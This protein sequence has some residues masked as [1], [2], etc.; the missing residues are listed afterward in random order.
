MSFRHHLI[1]LT[2]ILCIII[3]SVHADVPHLINFQGTLTDSAGN[4]I[5]GTRTMWFSIYSDSTGG[6]PLW[7]EQHNSIVIAEGLYHVILGS[8][9]P[10]PTSLFDGSTLWF[11][12]RIDPDPQELIPRQPLISV[13]YGYKSV[14]S[15][16]AN[17]LQVP[18]H[19]TGTPEQSGSI[20]WGTSTSNTGVGVL[21][22]NT[23]SGNTGMLGGLG[24]GVRGNNNNGNLGYLGYSGYGV[25]GYH[26]SGNWGLLGS[27]NYGVWGRH[28][29]NGNIGYLG[30]DSIGVYGYSTEYAGYFDG[31]L[32][33][34]GNVGIDTTNPTHKLVVVGQAISGVNS[35]ASGN[36]STINGGYDNTA[37]SPYTTV[38][39]GKENT[40][41]GYRSTVC[42]GYVNSA[43][44]W[45]ATISGGCYNI[46]DTMGST[47]GGGGG[48]QSTEIY[49]TIGGGGNNLAGGKYS[50]AGGGRENTASGDS[51]TV[52]G[53][54]QN[55]A[56]ALCAV[57]AG[58]CSQTADGEYSA[59]G[60]GSNNITSGLASTI[61][62]GMDNL[63]E[64]DYTIAMGQ[65][66]KAIHDGSFVWADGTGQDYVTTANNQFLIRAGGGVGIGTNNPQEQLDV[67]GKVSCSGLQETSDLR[68]KTDIQPITNALC[69]IEQLRGISFKWV[70]EAVS[71][72]ATLGSG[73]IGVI[74]QEV[75]HVF[76][77]LVTTPENGYKSVD[78]TKLTAVL[79]EAIKEL[80]LQNNVLQEDNRE[81]K[82]R[83]KALEA[84]IK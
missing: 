79:I 49:S 31:N 35:N 80:K 78:Y 28:Q 19:L 44:G 26:Y 62:G 57:I 2:M 37:S 32:I 83:I 77:E 67:A 66:A 68:L 45:D 11:G 81:M 51:S 1:I 25:Y 41:S 4:P 82:E 61:P 84:A 64:G 7:T 73:Q 47:V 39:G 72:G 40:A 55:T 10:I 20:I 58:G 56:S 30:G 33:I 46:A 24:W 9:T 54:N 14:R 60:G 70:P 63:T 53:G 29:I 12:V 42:G 27:S 5:T 71:V 21:G 6:T 50:F 74:A 59:I 76:P 17:T 69:K 8:T 23:H 16:T 48:N 3:V 75:E 15:D 18:L 34:T 43:G 36:Y 52:G 38:G 22:E 65:Q 13:P